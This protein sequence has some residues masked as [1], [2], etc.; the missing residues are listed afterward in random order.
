MQLVG[1][2]HGGG[3]FGVWVPLLQAKALIMGKLGEIGVITELLLCW[4]LGG[5]AVPS[6][7]LRMKE[8]EGAPRWQRWIYSV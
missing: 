1:N 2:P 5:E 4:G 7:V 8:P 3:G 6:W